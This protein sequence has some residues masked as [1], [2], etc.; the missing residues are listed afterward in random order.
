MKITK[1]FEEFQNF[2][3]NADKTGSWILLI[4]LKLLG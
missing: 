4:V 2:I 1:N 3:N